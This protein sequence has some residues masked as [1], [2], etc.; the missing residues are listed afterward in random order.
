[1]IYD[2]ILAKSILS[3]GS[4][5]VL[6]P[7]VSWTFLH[8]HTQVLKIRARNSNSRRDVNLQKKPAEGG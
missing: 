3:E 4:Y 5:V 1:M 2:V 7:T 6:R 8:I